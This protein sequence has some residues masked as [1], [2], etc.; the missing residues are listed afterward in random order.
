MSDDGAGVGHG[1]ADFLPEEVGV[2]G[3]LVG[4]EPILSIGFLFNGGVVASLGDIGGW[5]LVI[6][7]EVFDT[8][9]AEEAIEDTGEEGVSAEAVGAVIGE[10]GLAHGIE[11]VDAGHHV[12]WFAGF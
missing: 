9:G 11:A 1:F 12:G 7:A 10:A 3:S 8:C 2:F 6:V 4:E 5:L